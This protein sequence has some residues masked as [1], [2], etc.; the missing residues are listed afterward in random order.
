[1]MVQ[2]RCR[3]QRTRPE[4]GKGKGGRGE[5]GGEPFYMRCAIEGG[6]L[7]LLLAAAQSGEGA[8]TPAAIT[9]FKY[10]VAINSPLLLAAGAAAGA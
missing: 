9:S 3:G 2:A 4:L 7:L 6:C 8:V 10:D 1:M 5:A